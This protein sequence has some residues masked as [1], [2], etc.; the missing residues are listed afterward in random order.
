MSFQHCPVEAG[1]LVGK[2][3]SGARLDAMNRGFDVNGEWRYWQACCFP[4]GGGP[5][6]P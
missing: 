1:P 2:P 3:R 6:H 5:R 4:L